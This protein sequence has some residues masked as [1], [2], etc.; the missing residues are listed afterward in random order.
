MAIATARSTTTGPRVVWRFAGAPAAAPD[1]A[2]RQCGYLS[3]KGDVVREYRTQRGA[4]EEVCRHLDRTE[5]RLRR[6]GARFRRS[7][8]ESGE[9]RRATACL[10]ER[11][12][13]GCG[14]PAS[15]VHLVLEPVN[16]DLAIAA[17]TRASLPR[18]QLHRAPA[19][20]RVHPV[21]AGVVKRAEIAVVSRK[22]RIWST[23]LLTV[24]ASTSFGVIVSA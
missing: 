7:W 16:P 13:I 24:P 11:I 9:A 3:Q 14:R 5:A 6:A 10:A 18:H 2:L 15:L 4:H 21:V 1:P 22:A 20:R 17:F 12:P 8:R 19:E 23:T